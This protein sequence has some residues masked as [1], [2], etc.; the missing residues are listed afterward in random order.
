MKWCNMILCCCRHLL[1]IVYGNIATKGIRYNDD[2]FMVFTFITVM[3]YD[4]YTGIATKWIR[5]ND[6][7]FMVFTFC[8]HNKLW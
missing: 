3:E 6:D 2:W 8:I 4:R 1:P 5:Y 7:W